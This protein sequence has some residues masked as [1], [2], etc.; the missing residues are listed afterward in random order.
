MQKVI[1]ADS[2]KEGCIIRGRNKG[3]WEEDIMLRST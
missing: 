2:G 3:D 1:V